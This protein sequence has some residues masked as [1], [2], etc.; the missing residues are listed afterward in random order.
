MDLFN[1]IILILLLGSFLFGVICGLWYIISGVVSLILGVILASHYYE[2]L[3]LKLL[4]VVSGNLN[5][6]KILAFALIFLGVCIIVSLIFR[7]LKKVLKLIPFHGLINRLI[8]G[9]L[10][11]AMGGL[12][13]GF[14]LDLSTKFSLGPEWIAKIVSSEIALFLINLSHIL[15]PLIPQALQEI[16]SA[17]L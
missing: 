10:G 1:L 11:L 12:I 16:E 6:A 13:I 5:L 15:T 8:G 2:F 3:A 14:F 17:I 7:L 4:S 9:I